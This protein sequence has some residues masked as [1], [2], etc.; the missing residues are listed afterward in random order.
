MPSA[1]VGKSPPAGGRTVMAP[2]PKLR[3]LRG[4]FPADL[5]VKRVDKH[6]RGFRL[7]RSDRPKVLQRLG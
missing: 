1:P 4:T 3:A 7:V 2:N 5:T 6:L